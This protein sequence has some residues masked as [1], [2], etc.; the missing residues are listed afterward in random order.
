M[1]APLLSSVWLF[2]TLW[3][4]VH[5]LLCPW[6]SPGRRTGV[7][8]HALLQGGWNS[9]L[10]ESPALQADSWPTEPP[11]KPSLIWGE[12]NFELTTISTTPSE[13]AMAPHSSTLAWRIPG[14]G[15]AWW[16]AVYG[17]AQ[18]QTRLKWLSSS[19]HHSLLPCTSPTLSI[20][21][22]V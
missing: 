11:R 19:I 8:C 14:M 16:A 17:V 10:L 5:E 15:G 1:C 20:M 7:G 4:A 12:G 22:L 2:A 6:D 18:S 21:S 3:T 9:G 13:K